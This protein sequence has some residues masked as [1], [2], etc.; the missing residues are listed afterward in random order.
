[1]PTFNYTFN[2]IFERLSNK[3]MK[4]CKTRKL[5]VVIFL[6]CSIVFLSSCLTSKKMDAYISEQYNNEIPR[7]NKRKQPAEID[8]T[9]ALPSTSSTISATESHTKI[10]PLIV[11]WNIEERQTCTLNSRIATANFENT[12]NKIASRGLNQKLSGNKLELTVQQVPSSFALVD[13]T[14]AIWLIY[15][16]HWEKVYIEP[17]PGDLVVSY[18]LFRNDSTLKSGLITVKSTE[19]NKNLRFFQSWKSAVTEHLA[20]YDNDVAAMTQQ[21][22]NQLMQQL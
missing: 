8:Y 15:A 9:L 14:H 12:I 20:D 21:F 1:M 10:L 3:L 19:R 4:F 5:T 6:L 16:I 22:V 18:K 2:F 17:Q 11:Y 7:V 13:K